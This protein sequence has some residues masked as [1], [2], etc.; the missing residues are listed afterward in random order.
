MF[1][2]IRSLNHVSSIHT[3]MGGKETVTFRLVRAEN[4][5]GF[6]GKA[7]N[8]LRKSKTE[9]KAMMREEKEM[10][11][12]CRAGGIAVQHHGAAGFCNLSAMINSSGAQT[13]QHR[14]AETLAVC[15]VKGGLVL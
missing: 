2:Q 12:L 7:R 14:G 5:Y 15:T 9:A 1:S 13:W 8:P 6:N 10:E 3:R 11:Q 4:V